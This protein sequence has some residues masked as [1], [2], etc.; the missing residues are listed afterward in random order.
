MLYHREESCRR[1]G[2]K[3]REKNVILVGLI[4][5]KTEGKAYFI[6]TFCFSWEGSL[7]KQDRL[8]ASSIPTRNWKCF[9]LFF[10]PLPS[11]HHYMKCSFMW[12]LSLKTKIF[13][14]FRFLWL[15]RYLR[16]FPLWRGSPQIFIFLT[17]CHYIRFTNIEFISRIHIPEISDTRTLDTYQ[18]CY[19]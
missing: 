6:G 10:C 19:R 2:K 11:K 17:R 15:S 5:R 1:L 18:L 4:N 7:G 9:W 12:W 3:K 16:S 13:R 14:T 8:E